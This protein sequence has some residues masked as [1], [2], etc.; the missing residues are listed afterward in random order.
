MTS[1]FFQYLGTLLFLFSAFYVVGLFDV[2]YSSDH[3][4]L[5]N[6]AVEPD[7]YM[8]NARHYAREDM[9]VE[10]S[11]KHIDRAIEAIR[12]IENDID[13]N[14]KAEV[15]AAIEN[16]DRVYNEILADSVISQDMNKAF[17]F[18]LNTLALA[19]LRV[20]E[21]YAE[22]NNTDQAKVALKY[23]Q[24]HLKSAGQYANL[25]NLDKEHH[26]YY[27]IDS[28][29]KVGSM[30]PVLIVEKIDH[31]IAEMD[32]LVKEEKTTNFVKH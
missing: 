15:D 5:N 17:E 8:S 31:M 16:L 13:E 21:K 2:S 27:E 23:A 7:L 18:A 6:D 30:A 22:S 11:L 25:P 14:S 1:K 12:K 19:E 10:R 26:V 9:V 29:I 24:M 20:S 4:S 3:S 32:T 28:L